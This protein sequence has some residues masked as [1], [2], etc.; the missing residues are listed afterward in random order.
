[1]SLTSSVYWKKLSFE[2]FSRP[3]YFGIVRERQR[4]RNFCRSCIEITSDIVLESWVAG[5][6]CPGWIWMI[7][8]W[9]VRCLECLRA[10]FGGRRDTVQ[11]CCRCATVLR[12]TRFL[13]AWQDDCWLGPGRAYRD[14]VSQCFFFVAI[15]FG[16]LVKLLDYLSDDKM[17]ELCRRA[18]G[19]FE[20]TVHSKKKKDNENFFKK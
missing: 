3:R 17:L 16:Y 10:G 7:I 2:A 13:W 20:K 11:S 9:H 15:F 6:T 4:R 1:M 19:T 8:S 14:A 18:V 12:R 5:S